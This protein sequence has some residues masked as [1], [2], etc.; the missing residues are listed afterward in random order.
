MIFKDFNALF[1]KHV[2]ALFKDAQL[3]YETDIS[4]EDLWSTYLNAFPED[5]RQHHNC[6][7]CRQFLRPYANL[8]VIDSNYRV[9][10]IWD[11]VCDEP[12]QSVIQMLNTVVTAAPIRD[13]FVTVLKKLGT[14]S[15][16]QNVSGQFITWYHFHLVLPPH[17]VSRGSAV[18]EDSIRAAAF[19][20]HHIDQ[21]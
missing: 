3:V 12:Y 15:N 1:Q 8:V 2:D 9:R 20:F 7:C 11:F 4:K 14:L 13:V 18:S 19:E 6:N 5:L 17:L 16:V 10:S 21:K